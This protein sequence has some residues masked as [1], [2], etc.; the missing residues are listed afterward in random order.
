MK[1]SFTI[2][3]ADMFLKV[4]IRAQRPDEEAARL[5]KWLECRIQ[6][7]E[8]REDVSDEAAGGNQLTLHM[9]F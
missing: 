4:C 8:D 7:C 3:L 1:N 9:C 5:S 2:E 6:S